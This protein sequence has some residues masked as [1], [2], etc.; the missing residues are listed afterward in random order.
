MVKEQALKYAKLACDT[1]MRK[2]APQEL[3]PAHEFHY[4]QGVFLSGMHHTWQVCGEQKYFDYIKAW[5][6][7][8]VWDDGS[9]HDFDS[10]MLDDIQPGILL[11]ML[12]K[13]THAEKYVKAVETLM[14]ILKKWKKNRFGGFWHKA[15][16]ENQ[17]WLDGLYMAGPIAAEYALTFNHPEFLDTAI[18]QALLM[19]EHMTDKKT[20]LLYH[21]WD[22]NC[23]AW[24]V[25]KETSLSTEFWG[26]AMGWFVVAILD[27]LEFTPKDHPK[28]NILIEIEKNALEAVIKV[29]D[30]KSGMWYQ[31]LDK[32]YLS[33]NW[34]ESSCSAL[35]A[36]S[37][38]RAV[39][40]GIIDEKYITN[41][42]KAFDGIIEYYT[43]MDGEDLLV[44]GVCEGTDVSNYE[45][46]STRT[47]RINDL[48]G[49]GAFLLM[50]AEL[51]K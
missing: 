15:W 43:E 34:L 51:A 17:M 11:L 30:E 23:K 49:E 18:E 32:G 2:F 19:S 31:V 26:R 3:P 41:A 16:H 47:P 22:D 29:Q 1:M 37:I 48:H 6:D 50:C 5:V 7:D 25:N 12:Y 45:W 44:G 9:I 28:Y 46:Y 21:G 8:I 39:R 27:I 20:G 38:S 24:W 36:Y 40:M 13:E 33:D 4:H 10:G 14:A 35:F 42:E